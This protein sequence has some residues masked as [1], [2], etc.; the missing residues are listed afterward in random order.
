MAID[1]NTYPPPLRGRSDRAG[2]TVF[3]AIAIS[4]GFPM[5][6]FTGL[7]EPLR[8]ANG[9]LGRTAYAWQAVAEVAGQVAAS[10]GLE[11][12]A[13]GPIG[14][15]PLPDRAVICSG[16]E[17]S[18]TK[19]AG[20]IAWVRRA[21][22][23]GAQVGAVADGAFLLARAGLL[24]GRSCALHWTSH[25]AF[26]ETFPEVDLRRDRYVIDRARF[27][28]AGGVGAFDMTLALIALD[29]GE[30]LAAA[31]AEWFVHRRPG[32]RQDA[33]DGPLS[34]RIRTSDPLVLAAARNMEE[35]IED[36]LPIA[37]V[38]LALRVSRDR[39]E[40]AFRRELGVS[41]AEWRRE[42]RVRRAT[43]L[44][45]NS[46]MPVAQVAIASGH[47]DP[48]AFARRYRTATGRTPLQV[49]RDRRA[50]DGPGAA[51][52]ANGTID[53]AD[54]MAKAPSR[55]DDRACDSRH[56]PSED[57]ADRQTD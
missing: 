52:A 13:A 50:E 53:A 34:H 7:V 12:A 17:A 41:P 25:A 26:A 29:H 45:V 39:L 21:A 43:D 47:A 32:P 18:R 49:R 3:T 48:S 4:H 42:A 54:G 37:A 31:V 36:A 51:L 20:T 11:L 16:G 30:P 1:H 10:N 35:R 38:A 19:A 5:L 27:T 8:A 9:L 14:T 55:G 46:A 15:L 22:A 44:L 57:D 56:I 23:S 33:R 2:R 24:A 6:A 28:S 40:R